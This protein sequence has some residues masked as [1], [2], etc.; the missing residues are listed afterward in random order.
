MHAM[1]FGLIHTFAVCLVLHSIGFDKAAGYDVILDV[2]ATLGFTWLYAGTYSGT[3][4]GIFA[5]LFMS[6]YMRLYRHWFGYSKL[7]R[8]GWLYYHN[9]RDYPDWNIGVK[10]P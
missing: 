10:L 7:T 3:T 6:L 8:H 4:V 1:F 5:G 9:N 2:A